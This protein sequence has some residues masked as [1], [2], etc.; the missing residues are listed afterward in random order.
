[1]ILGPIWYPLGSF[2]GPAW[3]LSGSI[4]NVVGDVD[5]FLKPH[6]CELFGVRC[7]LFAWAWGVEE[8]ARRVVLLMSSL[9]ESIRTV[10][11]REQTVS[12]RK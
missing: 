1:M 11:E 9:F 2:L 8:I 10:Y 4:W 7:E 5:A 12:V 6:L 3:H